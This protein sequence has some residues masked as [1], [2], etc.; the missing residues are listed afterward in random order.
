MQLINFENIKSKHDNADVKDSE[1][2]LTITA[3]FGAYIHGLAGDEA[4]KVCGTYGLLASDIIKYMKYVL[5][6]VKN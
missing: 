4:K 5:K 3:A 1:A 2:L 6:E